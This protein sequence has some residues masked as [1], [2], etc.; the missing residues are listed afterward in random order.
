[1]TEG[2]RYFRKLRILTILVIILLVLTTVTVIILY[3]ENRGQN[4]VLS[5]IITIIFLLFYLFFCYY[6]P[7]LGSKEPYAGALKSGTSMGFWAGITWMI[8]LT[9][10]R[11]IHLPG[12]AGTFVD[13]GFMCLV[14]LIFGYSAYRCMKRTN[15]MLASLLSALW[16]SMFSILILFIYSWIMT[17]LFM[18]R[19]EE[20]MITDP[21]YLISGMI[22]IS[23]Y[24]IHH[25]IESA[26]IHL[27]EAPLLALIIGLIGVFVYRV[28]NKVHL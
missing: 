19:I 20:V 12:V 10:V 6:L 14:L 25:N 13:L 23:D 7:F 5:W 27:L 2:S 28:R 18:N 26:G 8:H 4:G 11:F 9:L 16:G 24:T 17:F 22:N 15:H 21:D 1:M 3:P